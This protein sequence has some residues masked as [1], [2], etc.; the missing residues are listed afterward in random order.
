MYRTEGRLG[1]V[2][3]PYRLCSVCSAPPDCFTCPCPL[4]G[5]QQGFALGLATSVFTLAKQKALG[6]GTKPVL[7]S[8]FLHAFWHSVLPVSAFSACDANSCGM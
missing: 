6:E 3:E 8:H 4:I 5:S 7:G 2:V 1:L